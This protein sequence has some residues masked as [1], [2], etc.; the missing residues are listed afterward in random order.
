[1]HAVAAT[2]PGFLDSLREPG[3]RTA[4]SP[5]RLADALEL[6]IQELAEL[7]RVHRN[8]IQSAPTSPKLQSAMR[9]VVRV[10]SAAHA[11]SGDID[12]TLFWFRNHPIADFGHLTPIEL[13]EQG[14]VQA[15]IDYIESL[16]AG[17]SG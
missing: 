9:D 10:L 12:R 1:M 14:K 11:L 15:V 16:A 5:S 7:A 2:F 3:S 17:A 8:T 4:L 6:P 13:V